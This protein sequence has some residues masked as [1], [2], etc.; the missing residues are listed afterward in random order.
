MR[1]SAEQPNDQSPTSAR[2]RSSSSAKFKNAQG[3]RDHAGSCGL[4]SQARLGSPAF[5]GKRRIEVGFATTETGK[6]TITVY[7]GRKKVKSVS[8][9]VTSANRFAVVRIK[10]KGK[11]FKRGEYKVKIS[12]SGSSTRKTVNL[13]AKKY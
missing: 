8:K 11:K 12:F 1:F 9:K 6:A 7:R 13:Y 10:P 5:G 2:S 4:I 3:L